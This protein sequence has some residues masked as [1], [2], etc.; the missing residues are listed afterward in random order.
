V[1][2]TA[3]LPDG[4]A[5]ANQVQV[6]GVSDTFAAL[7]SSRSLGNIPPDSVVLNAAL[8]SHLNVKSGD[9]VVLRVHKFEAMS[10][11]S[12]VAP[13]DDAIVLRLTVRG[14]ASAAELGNLQASP[15]IS[16]RRSTRS[17]VSICSSRN[18]TRPSAAGISCS[19]PP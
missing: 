13:K 5:R 17:F 2:A 18:S 11:D 1:S 16:F 14:I 3:A 12:P 6:L 15:R 10:G 8:A 19:R 4:S 9:T 7:A